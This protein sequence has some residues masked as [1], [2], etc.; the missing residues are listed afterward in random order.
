[1][2]IPLWQKRHADTRKQAFSTQDMSLATG[3]GI[4]S[5]TADAP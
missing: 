5:E 3:I 2:A 1:M 4:S